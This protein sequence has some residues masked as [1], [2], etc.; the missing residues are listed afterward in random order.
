MSFYYNLLTTVWSKLNTENCLRRYHKLFFWHLIIKIQFA[1]LYTVLMAR[2]QNDNSLAKVILTDLAGVGCL[3]LVPILGPL[4]GP[5]G[6][7]LLLA[8]FG[9]FAVNHDWAD[10]AVHYIKKHSESLQSVIFPDKTL[11]KWAWDVT[12]VL[13]LVT[14][15]LMNIYA[16]HWFFSAMSYGVMAGSTTLFMLNRNRLAW[17][18]KAL[19]RTG[20]R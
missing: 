16:E 17:L 1:N 20:K 10:D 11:I 19:R 3:I 7:P 9:F 15:A 8:G 5:G 4:P 18:D 2:K 13:I 12:A 6:I 14:G